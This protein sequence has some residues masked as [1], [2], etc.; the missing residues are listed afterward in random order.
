ML[1]IDYSSG[2]VDLS[3]KIAKSRG[4]EAI[5]F[6][7]VDFISGEPPHLEGMKEGEGWNLL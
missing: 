1:G 3:K 4:W 7:V 5:R 6:E 2:S